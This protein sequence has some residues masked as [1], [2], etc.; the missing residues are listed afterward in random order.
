MASISTQTI[1]ALVRYGK[2]SADNLAEIEGWHTA[3]I[4]EIAENKGGHLVSGSTNGSTFTQIASMTNAQWLGVL[5]T[6]LQHIESGTTPQTRTIA[7]LC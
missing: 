3:A 7:R 4:K 1:R 2:A 5:E 6:V